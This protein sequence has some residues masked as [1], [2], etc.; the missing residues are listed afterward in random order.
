MA[1]SLRERLNDLAS[2]FASRVLEAIRGSSLE[3]LLAQSSRG[4]NP[5]VARAL[6]RAHGPG[7]RSRGGRLPRRSAH[8]ISDVVEQIAGVL[9]QHPGGLRAEQIR[10]ELGL[11][12]KELPRPLKEGL[13]SGRFSKAGQKRATTYF[14]KNGGRGV[15]R[16][17]ASRRARPSRTRGRRTKRARQ[18]K[19]RQGGVTTTAL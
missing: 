15:V 8:A 10:E 19:E 16:S 1:H 5:G 4:G 2:M 7:P 6:A 18:L 11:Q 14:V 9:R 12:A 13:D 17:R 3:E